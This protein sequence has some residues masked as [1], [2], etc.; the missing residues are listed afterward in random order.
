[1]ENRENN[2]RVIINS[3][4]DEDYLTKKRHHTPR[5]SLESLINKNQKLEEYRELLTEIYSAKEL[6]SVVF[7]KVK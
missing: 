5:K 6:E 7:L 4:S 1:M 3:I 2:N